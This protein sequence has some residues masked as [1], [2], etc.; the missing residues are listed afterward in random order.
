MLS[1]PSGAIPRDGKNW[2][3]DLNEDGLIDMN[4]IQDG[5]S[6]AK[7]AADGYWS[8]QHFKEV[9][10]TTV[11]RDAQ[12]IQVDQFNQTIDQDLDKFLKQ[13]GITLD[14][15]KTE[16][17]DAKFNSWMTLLSAVV[18]GGAAIVS[19]KRSGGTNSGGGG[20]S[21]GISFGTSGPT[22]T[23]GPKK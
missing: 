13:M 7:K 22:V 9:P 23:V 12:G 10:L 17:S 4:D 5:V 21:A 11:D 18:S 14:Q 20:I 8:F 15:I 2:G 3:L 19:A 6:T 16:S 1:A